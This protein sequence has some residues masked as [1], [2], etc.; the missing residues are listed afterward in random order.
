MARSTN[1]SNVEFRVN[2][3]VARYPAEIDENCIALHAGN[4]RADLVCEAGR[5]S[6]VQRRD[7]KSVVGA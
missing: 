6:T 2:P 3:G 5:L 1:A 4:Q 7:L